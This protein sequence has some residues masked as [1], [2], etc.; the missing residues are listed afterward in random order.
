[1]KHKIFFICLISLILG[2][3]LGWMG[4]SRFERGQF[5]MA[6]FMDNTTVLAYL[7]KGETAAAMMLLSTSA[8][9]NMVL[10]QEYGDLRLKIHDPEAV[11]RWILRYSLLRESLP[12][13]SRPYFD[14][15]NEAEV[16][17]I[18]NNAKGK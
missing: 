5:A 17:K 4:G 2:A 15:E 6:S 11:N 8:D 10:T 13:K 1:M 16:K 9:A 3:V 18:I 14:V 7:Q 12:E